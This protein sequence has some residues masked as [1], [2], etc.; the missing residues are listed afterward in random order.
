VASGMAT[1]IKM[2]QE[3]QKVAAKLPFPEG[4]VEIINVEFSQFGTL[5]REQAKV[6]KSYYDHVSDKVEGVYFPAPVYNAI[7]SINDVVYKAGDTADKVM[8]LALK[9]CQNLLD[10]LD[11]PTKSYWDQRANKGGSGRAKPAA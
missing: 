11:D 10:D 7:M 1:L 3:M 6:F 8:P 5:V 4:A 9:V 2:A